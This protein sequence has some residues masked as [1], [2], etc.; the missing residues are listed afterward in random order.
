ML[1]LFDINELISESIQAYA[2]ALNAIHAKG[3]FYPGI[4]TVSE[5]NLNHN[6][7][8]IIFP[9]KQQTNPRG[10]TLKLLLGNQWLCS[11]INKTK[12]FLRNKPESMRNYWNDWRIKTD[13]GKDAALGMMGECLHQQQLLRG[14]PIHG[15]MAK[16]REDLAIAWDLLGEFVTDTYFP[17]TEDMVERPGGTVLSYD[18][19]ARM[20]FAHKDTQLHFSH[21]MQIWGGGASEQ[22]FLGVLKAFSH[23]ENFLGTLPGTMGYMHKEREAWVF[24]DPADLYLKEQTMC[25]H[26]THAYSSAAKVLLRDLVR[27]KH[28]ATKDQAE[29][30]M[31]LIQ[32]FFF[33]QSSKDQLAN[34]NTIKAK[35]SPGMTVVFDKVTR[36]RDWAIDGKWLQTQK[37][38]SDRLSPSFV[39]A[40][41]HCEWRQTSIMSSLIPPGMRWGL[42]APLVSS[43][44]IARLPRLTRTMPGN[45]PTWEHFAP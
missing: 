10:E 30:G 18:K 29:K 21:Y 35:L 28:W 1:T 4:L 17:L 19:R 31:G 25:P 23:P 33:A 12:V 16:G 22:N 27:F 2:C 43:R 44:T 45:P 20:D 34:P 3:N 9:A 24:P 5:E 36:C 7:G 14:L 26:F 11:V 39:R 41:A 8:I 32:P 37:N 38:E 13:L 40:I 42:V 6:G 15:S